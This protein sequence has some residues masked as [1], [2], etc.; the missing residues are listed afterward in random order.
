MLNSTE[1]FLK[2]RQADKKIGGGEPLSHIYV[3]TAT[4]SLE[5]G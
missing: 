2:K 4:Y 1:E 3:H 5:K